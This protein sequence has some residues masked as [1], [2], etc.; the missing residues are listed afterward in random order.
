MPKCARKLRAKLQL[1]SKPLA[2]ATSPIV[3]DV[4]A[5][6]L[7]AWSRRMLAQAAC[8][9]SPYSLW[10]TLEKYQVENRVRSASSADADDAMAMPFHDRGWRAACARTPG[11]CAPSDAPG[12]SADADCGTR[13][14]CPPAHSSMRT[15]R[16]PDATA[17]PLLSQVACGAIPQAGDRARLA[18]VDMWPRP[19][20]RSKSEKRVIAFSASSAIVTPMQMPLA[21]PGSAAR[22]P[23]RTRSSRRRAGRTALP[24]LRPRAAPRIWIQTERSWLWNSTLPRREAPMHR[25]H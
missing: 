20:Y 24:W 16:A 1:L 7:A 8:G 13:P 12:H 15:Q 21:P 5:S 3:I 19:T 2:T 18:R 4:D 17:A 22:N 9:L 14:A 11:A 10:K 23:S 6:R 25:A